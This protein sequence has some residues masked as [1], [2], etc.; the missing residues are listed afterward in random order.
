MPIAALPPSTAQAIGS[1]SVLPNPCAVVKELIDNGLDAGATSI[2]VEISPNSVDII[3]VKDN[4]HGV[5]SEDFENLCKRAYTSKIRTLDDLRNI[6]GQSLGFRGF[7]LASATDMVDSLTVTTRTKNDVVASVL[8][9]DAQGRLVSTEKASH[10]VGT[11]VC[12][13]GFLKKI[14]VRRQAAVKSASKTISKIKKLLQAYAMARLGIRLSLKVLN[15]RNEKDNWTYAPSSTA[16]IVD[17]SRKVVGVETAGQ[18]E[19]K[20]WPENVEDSIPSVNLLAY[21]PKADSDFSKVNNSSQY[22]S[23]DG[24]PL[25]SDRGTA[26]E[27]IEL[28]KSY[29]RS[30]AKA[31]GNSTLGDPFLSLHISC[32]PGA[33]DANV[34]PAKDDVLFAEREELFQTV[35]D[36]FKATYGEPQTAADS[37]KKQPSSVN[38]FSVLLRQPAIQKPVSPPTTNQLPTLTRE[39]RNVEDL[40]ATLAAHSTDD[41]LSEAEQPE[42]ASKD[43]G[44]NPWSIAKTHFFHH[45]SKSR[46]ESQFVTPTRPSFRPTGGRNAGATQSSP[47]EISSPYSQQSSPDDGPCTSR[48]SISSSSR[49]AGRSNSYTRPSRERDRERYGNGS[50]DTWFIKNTGPRLPNRSP[51][52]TLDDDLETESVMLDNL[53]N[54]TTEKSPRITNKPFKVPLPNHSNKSQ[55]RQPLLSP[56]AE[57]ISAESERRQEFPV[58]EEWSARL[59]QNFPDDQSVFSSQDTERALDFERRKKA[60]NLARR[61]QLLKSRQTYLASPASSQ[62]AANSPHT[63]RYLAARVTHLQ[64]SQE[65]QSSQLQKVQSTSSD[66]FMKE[67]DPRKY[68]MQHQS[69]LRSSRANDATKK[70]KPIPTS[71]FP[72]E[73]IPKGFDMHNLGMRLNI[74]LPLLTKQCSFMAGVDCFVSHK[75]EYSPFGPDEPN[76]PEICKIWEVTIA[77]LIKEKYRLKEVDLYDAAGGSDEAFTEGIDIYTAIQSN[78]SR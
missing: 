46:Q 51:G 40:A 9:Y 8:E 67:N 56:G 20:A 73:N 37:T 74:S 3:Q 34:E 16:S 18:C 13:N 48:R 77:K 27:I 59:H 41:S 29:V 75:G 71:R 38:G 2:S 23:V 78:L 35:E 19:S 49:E 39:S 32:P 65:S 43:N 30:A 55:S 54:Q 33:Y 66:G 64:Y 63:N 5:A 10:T 4:G 14:P 24:R 68:L 17:A 28:Y 57:P 25:S 15:G 11:S 31:T 44:I 45:S 22:I 58:M 50:L 52:E 7:A 62:P 69:E 72:L 61:Q 70:Q 21:L 42:V 53:H 1:T 76:L 60:A 47:S 12:L 26:K 36:M 6:G